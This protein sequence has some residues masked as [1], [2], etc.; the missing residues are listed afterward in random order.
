MAKGL[1]YHDQP[2]RIP[3]REGDAFQ[4]ETGRRGALHV[5]AKPDGQEEVCGRLDA[6]R[7]HVR[8]GVPVTE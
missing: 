5:E 2:I 6:L 3:K 8:G 4:P 1:D 7:R